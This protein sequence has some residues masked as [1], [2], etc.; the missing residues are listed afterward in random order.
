MGN[1]PEAPYSAPYVVFDRKEW[2]R[3]RGTF[4]VEISGQEIDAIRSL[5]DRIA[6]EEARDIYFPLSRLIALYIRARTGL[7]E[8]QNEFLG[9]NPRKV[10]YVIGVTGSVAVGKS[11]TSRMLKIL[12][13]RSPGKPK[14]D[15]VTT[16]GFLF[17]NSV[18]EERGI[19]SRKGFPE[20]YDLRALINFITRVKAGEKSVRAPVY[21]HLEYDIVPGGFI[22]VDNPD[23][24]ILEGL[25]IMQSRSDMISH[26]VSSAFVSD[27]IDFSVF[28]D[29][30]EEWIKKWFIERFLILKETAFQ[31]EKSYFRKLGS[32]SVEEAIS[33]AEDIWDKINGLNYRKNIV[34][35]KWKAH[36]IL[37]KD[38]DHSVERILMRRL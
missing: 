26:P 27:Y 10:P 37:E 3:K 7:Y 5:N 20:S 8:A 23:V 38:L 25:N 29:A 9:D 30:R 35:T 4:N 19:M 28:V 31:E 12:L 33:V 1:D 16:D 17:P 13:E 15:L 21:S 14:V 22:T 6:I 11:T 18:L 34:H 24:L 32:L 36:L 2:S